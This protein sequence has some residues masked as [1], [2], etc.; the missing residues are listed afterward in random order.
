M[1]EGGP[2]AWRAGRMRRSRGLVAPALLLAGG[3]A[4]M[5]LAP[6]NLDPAATFA[7]YRESG[8]FVLARADGR[9]GAAA[10]A[11]W[12]GG[13][14]RYAVELGGERLGEVR[15]PSPGRAE[16]VGA[17]GET[18]SVA[19][20]WDDGAIRL[21][22]QVGTAGRLRTLGFRRVETSAGST[23]L[24]RNVPSTL[25]LRG[26]Y[27]GEWRDG[28]GQPVGWLQLRVWYPSGRRV[29][30]GVFPPGYPV[31]GAVAA[32]VALDA[33]VEWIQRWAVPTI[34]PPGPAAW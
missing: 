29:Y 19:P 3:C 18:G 11:G 2:P 30:E 20:T 32:A 6:P 24:T 23:V 34:R 15:V 5:G 14:P 12:S 8:G 17:H 1:G 33:E 10:A 26:T 25:D 9:S 4:T 22:L 7:A 31:I 16:I 13:A 21:A 27:R 28:A